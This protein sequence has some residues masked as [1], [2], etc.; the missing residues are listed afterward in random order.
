[1][2]HVINLM[3]IELKVVL[4]LML[5]LLCFSFTS[6]IRNEN[7]TNSETKINFFYD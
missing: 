3:N 6:Y 4:D 5:R 2:L 7:H 1:M